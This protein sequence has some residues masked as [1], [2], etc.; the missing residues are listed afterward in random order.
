MMPTTA[1]TTNGTARSSWEHCRT[2]RRL[3]V[4]KRSP[5]AALHSQEYYRYHYH[6]DCN[7][8]YD[9]NYHNCYYHYNYNYH[10]HYHYHYS[11]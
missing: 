5:Y 9:H 4:R 8:N 2:I 6:Y 11:Q 3:S 1:I 7:H 10:Y